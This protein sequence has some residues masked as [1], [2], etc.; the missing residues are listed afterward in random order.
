MTHERTYRAALS[1]DDAIENITKKKK[2]KWKK[3]L[4]DVFV[5]MINETKRNN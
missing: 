3:E 1:E 5:G 4:V 2:K